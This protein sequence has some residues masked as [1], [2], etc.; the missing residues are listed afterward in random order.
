MFGFR[1]R[2]KGS[3]VPGLGEAKNAISVPE[4]AFLALC[5]PPNGK[6]AIS[7]TEIAFFACPSFGFGIS[8][9]GVRLRVNRPWGGQKRNFRARNCVFACLRPFNGAFFLVA[10]KSTKLRFCLPQALC[11]LQGRK[12]PKTQFQAPKLRFWPPQALKPFN[13]PTLHPDP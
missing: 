12:E 10:L 2:V 1:I 9:V 5:D 4:I 3:R 6:N 8:V 11:R 13:P 7:G